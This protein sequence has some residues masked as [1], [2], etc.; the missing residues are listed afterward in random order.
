MRL[1]LLARVPT[2]VA[3]RDLLD[4]APGDHVTLAW[5]MDRLHER[6]FGLVILLLAVVALV[7]GLAIF[8]A[9]L[10]AVPAVQ[11]ILARDHPVL[12]GALTNRRLPMRQFSRSVER[13]VPLLRRMER[14]IR[15]RWAARSVATSRAVGGLFLLLALSM[16]GPIPFSHIPPAIVIIVMALAYMEEDGMMLCASA[17]VGASVSLSI[18][19]ASA[20][21]AVEGLE[22]LDRM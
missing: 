2:S 15:P 4:Q 6:S 21:A 16:M 10:M 3:L 1:S 20:W 5:I 17:I 11:M 12:P 18:T 8:A 19:A 7:P 22:I 9:L 14:L 13:L